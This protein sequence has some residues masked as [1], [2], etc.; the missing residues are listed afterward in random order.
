MSN[1]IDNKLKYFYI[2]LDEAIYKCAS[3]TCLYP[4]ER[5]IFKNLKDNSIYNY[6]EVLDGGREA[7]FR[8]KFDEPSIVQSKNPLSTKWFTDS[9]RNPDIENYDFSDL[10]DNFDADAPI[11]TDSQSST[12]NPDSLEFLDDTVPP[13]HIDELNNDK[14]LDV[15]GIDNIIDSLLKESPIKK[16]PSAKSVKA[17]GEKISKSKTSIKAKSQAKPSKSIQ[18]IEKIKSSKRQKQSENTFTKTIQ[19]ARKGQLK[20]KKRDEQ[21]PVKIETNPMPKEE[22]RTKSKPVSTLCSSSK[23]IRPSLLAK[24]LISMDANQINS[25]FLRHYMKVKEETLFA[26]EPSINSEPIKKATNAIESVISSSSKQQISKIETATSEKEAKSA[27]VRKSKM[28]SSRK[29]IKKEPTTEDNV[30]PKTDNNKSRTTKPRTSKPKTIKTDA[31]ERKEQSNEK[32]FDSNEVTVKVEKLTE[33]K[34]PRKRTTSRK[35]ETLIENKVMGVSSHLTEIE[36]NKKCQ[37]KISSTVT[38]GAFEAIVKKESSKRGRKK[39]KRVE[40]AGDVENED[41]KPKRRRISKKTKNA[42]QP[43]LP[44]MI[45]NDGTGEFDLST[46]LSLQF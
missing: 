24:E 14:V 44:T 45:A 35:K 39:E 46:I 20:A 30:A 3:S 16:K 38:S 40:N 34:T 13:Q 25:N 5:F 9:Q 43:S 8:V 42:E 10:F 12:V 33:K 19:K 4:F 41:P 29:T 32:A 27:I 6:E 18:C 11:E 15:N 2:S 26:D 36:T 31:N 1:G 21:L 37:K 7:V 22:V 17:N 28:S 23:T